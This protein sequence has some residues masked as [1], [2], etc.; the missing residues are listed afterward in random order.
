MNKEF[1]MVPNRVF[2]V[3]LSTTEIAVFC[4]LLRCA[5]NDT[6]LC[7]P[8][9]KN[10]CERCKISRQSAITTIKSLCDHNFIEKVSK[11]YSGEYGVKRANTY[12]VTW[13]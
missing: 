5:D 12:K 7:F 1:F 6:K 11:G 9:Y 4:Y 3:G 13:Y 10:I 8:S 2:D